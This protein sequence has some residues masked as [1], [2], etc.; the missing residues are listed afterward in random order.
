MVEDQGRG[1]LFEKGT[2][3]SVSELIEFLKTFP[4]DMPVCYRFCSDFALLEA[5]EIT[6]AKL[7]F[8]RTD[9]YVHDARPDKDGTEYL[10]LPGN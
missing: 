8:A 5:K 4:G 6:T 1:I 7:Q 9:G 3:M 2:T 10:I